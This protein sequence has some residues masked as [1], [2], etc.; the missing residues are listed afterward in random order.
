M[1]QEILTAIHLCGYNCC[2]HKTIRAASDA[3]G[4]TLVVWQ[5]IFLTGAESAWLA[6]RL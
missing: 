2:L 1:A 3:N 4:S 6:T 5:P